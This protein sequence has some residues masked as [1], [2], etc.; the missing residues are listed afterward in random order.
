M[1]GR[2]L[3][4][5][6][7]EV[8]LFS[9]EVH[10]WRLDPKDWGTVLDAVRWLGFM[11]VATYV[12]WAEHEIAEGRYDFSGR[13]D[14]E[15][16]LGLVHERGMYALVR[17]G[18][19][20]ASELTT[21]G[22]SRRVLDDPRTQARRSNG[23][24]YILVTP[25]SWVFAPS[26]ASKVFLGE[27]AR[28]Y[29]EI[30]PRLAALQYPNGPVVAC[31]V[32]NEM[33]YHFQANSYALDYHPDA[34]AEYR[35]F[36]A[37]K[38]SDPSSM[39]EA[40]GFEVGSFHDA[41]PPVDGRDGPEAKRTDWVEWRERHLIGAIGRLSAMARDRGIHVPITHNDYPRMTTPMNPTGLERS[42]AVD[43]AAGDV[44]APKEGAS[45]VREFARFL[46]G[47]SR[48]PFL[49]EMG[50]GF[51]TVPWLLPMKVQPADEEAIDVR[52]FCCGVKAANVYMLVERDRWYSSPITERGELRPN[53]TLYRRL[54]ELKG[55]LFP[56]A[57]WAPALLLE[58]RAEARKDAALDIAGTAVQ[59]FPPMLPL[60]HRLFRFSSGAGVK[61]YEQWDKELAAELQKGGI[62]Y[63][64][65]STA[66]LPD[67]SPYE[68]VIVP[69]FDQ[70][71]K[72]VVDAL[73]AAA[74]RGVRIVAG[75]ESGGMTGDEIEVIS[76]PSMLGPFLPAPRFVCDNQNIELHLFQ[77]EQDILAA[78]NNGAEQEAGTIRAGEAFGLEGVWEHESLRG[79]GSVD[80]ALRPWAVQ[81]WKVMA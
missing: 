34:L 76:D 23:D 14:I 75:P 81:V 44:Y 45:Y 29:D 37:S 60:D 47:T 73:K 11:F 38:Y 6:E 67:L 35:D 55:R 69:A 79:E 68:V 77:G 61:R 65:A 4:I 21:S 57:R 59:S 50:A 19:D 26:Y 58:N 15:R 30:V 7:D 17:P 10:Y 71:D 13:L 49:A 8:S 66:T 72:A 62:D 18:P 12:P 36:L 24:P 42:G 64:R 70:L 54:T 41:Q 43:V 74:G 28:W 56:L 1:T 25:T 48:L 46:S 5:G 39:S 2:G 63:D 3:L 53:A 31:Q 40:Y 20:C 52:A 27:V 78:L 9:G 33:G 22:W 16:F 51:I 80:V 32:D